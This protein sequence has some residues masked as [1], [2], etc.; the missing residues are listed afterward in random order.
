[1]QMNNCNQK[2]FRSEVKIGKNFM[3]ITSIS[4]GSYGFNAL[5]IINI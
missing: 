3:Q 4:Q 2:Y 5:I 1:M